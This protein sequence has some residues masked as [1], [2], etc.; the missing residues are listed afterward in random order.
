MTTKTKAAARCT[1]C[2]SVFVAWQ[3]SDGTIIPIGTAN[4]CSCGETEFQ[5]LEEASSTE[6]R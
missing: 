1:A 5:V 6:L 2:E 4:R 3:S